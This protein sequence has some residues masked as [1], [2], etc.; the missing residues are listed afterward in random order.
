M[1]QARRLVALFL[2]SLM[3]PPPSAWALGDLSILGHARSGFGFADPTAGIAMA[4]AAVLPDGS[5]SYG[6]PIQVPPGTAGAQPEIQLTYRS[7]DRMD[8]WVGVGW[9]LGFG[10]I[11]RS[12]REGVPAYHDAIDVF[13]LD[14]MDL[15]PAAPGAARFHTR[16]ETFQKIER[17]SWSPSS[18]PPW[19]PDPDGDTWEARSP[20]G[21]IRRYGIDSGPSDKPHPDAPTYSRIVNAQGQTYA[22]LLAEIEDTHGNVVRIT[23]DAS[24]PGV[25]YPAEARY[26]LRRS[27]T[28]VV[29]LNGSAPPQAM[30]RV[31]TF[32]LE[33]RPDP[34]LRYSAGLEQR[35]TQRLDRIDVSV[36]GQV[37]RRYELSHELSPDS[38]RSRLVAVADHG[39]TAGSPA[40]PL[41]TSFTYRD[42]PVASDHWPV[43]PSWTFPDPKVAFVLSTFTDGG[44]RLGDM[45]QDGYPDLVRFITSHEEV[46]QAENGVYLNLGGA[47]FSASRTLGY[48]LPTPPDNGLVLY[49]NHAFSA[50]LI[51]CPIFFCLPYEINGTGSELVDLDRDGLP[52]F[53]AA[54][55]HLFA[56]DTD[57][58]WNLGVFDLF[59]YSSGQATWVNVQREFH[60]F[61][62][63][64]DPLSIPVSGWSEGLAAYALG[65]MIGEDAFSNITPYPH[66]SKTSIV[67]LNGDGRPDLLTSSRVVGYAEPRTERSYALARKDGGGFDPP[68]S[69]RYT[70]CNTED[71]ACLAVSITTEFD[72]NDP[73][74]Y[75]QGVTRNGGRYFDI[76]GDGLDDYVIANKD[77]GLRAVYLNDGTDFADHS[78]EWGLPA[79]V[80]FDDEDEELVSRDQGWR[81]ID[82][83]G[84]ARVDLVR[85]TEGHAHETWLNTGNTAALWVAAPDWAVPA[86]LDFTNAD[87][88][89]RGVRVADLDGD[90]LLDFVRI[91]QGETPSVH[92]NDALRPDLLEAIELPY[93]GSTSYVYEDHP[94]IPGMGSIP[95]VASTTTD[96]ARGTTGTTT[97]Q[98][99]GGTYD[100]GRREFRGFTT[101]TATRPID[102]RRTITTYHQEE[103]LFGLVESIRIESGDP[104]SPIPWVDRF[105]EYADPGAAV[106][107]PRDGRGARRVRG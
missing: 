58:P 72:V 74:H 67:E 22:W 26:T 37:V 20:D 29:S 33:S 24:D 85:A 106:P 5:A 78:T 19:S 68:S 97:Y 51:A 102:S 88:Q 60:E 18:T 107:Q 7:S 55:N 83:N 28:S 23:Y 90:G 38:F 70:I 86:A 3:A 31:V 63:P 32:V 52:E 77:T 8:S 75:L 17:V 25:R 2:V 71:P 69:D 47:G 50:V 34:T 89:D 27:G 12:I 91:Q 44:T 82:V 92:L 11:R 1:L 4:P 103:G 73:A 66:G 40:T 45:N 54:W 76:N 57:L 62:D 64:N 100:P 6:Y 84:D 21:T 101:V 49:A 81:I 104:G 94:P 87:G 61:H 16:R 36:E 80:W 10:E 9:S 79:G 105:V 99:D 48:E 95:V 15:V 42:Q 13:Q 93:G 30:D 39:S 43:D 98:Y 35:M 41:V 65:L 56:T 59:R 46:T 96:D 14:G 53:L